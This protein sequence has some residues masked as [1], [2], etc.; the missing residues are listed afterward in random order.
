MGRLLSAFVSSLL[1]NWDFSAGRIFLCVLFVSVMLGRQT[2]AAHLGHRP[3]W[4]EWIQRKGLKYP[5]QILELRKTS[6][7][8]S[9]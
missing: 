1:L 2:A 8:V 5:S 3:F 4:H 6:T 7:P 9:Q